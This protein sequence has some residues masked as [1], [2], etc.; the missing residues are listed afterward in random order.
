M[1]FFLLNI[2][3][4]FLFRTLQL[5]VCLLFWGNEEYNLLAFITEGYLFQ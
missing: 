4:L 3:Q 2:G 5:S 1:V